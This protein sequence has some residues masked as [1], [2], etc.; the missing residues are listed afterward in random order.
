MCRFDEH[1]FSADSSTPSLARAFTVEHLHQALGSDA[2]DSGLL[3]DAGLVVSELV[4]NSVK[5]GASEIEVGL[6]IHHDHI[7]LAVADDAAGEPAVRSPSP[8]ATGGRGLH[9][10]EQLARRWGTVP[11]PSGKQVWAE[12][13]ADPA[14]LASVVC[15][16]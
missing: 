6:A 8:H 2:A 1:A 3:E 10:I 16:I 12:L 11:T 13:A 4:T 5:A 14:A 7:R 9:I 15:T